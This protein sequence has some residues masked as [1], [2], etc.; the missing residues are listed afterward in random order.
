MDDKSSQVQ[1]KSSQQVTGNDEDVELEGF[2]VSQQSDPT[3]FKKAKLSGD[4]EAIKA[5]EFGT[6]D[7][8]Y[9]SENES[10]PVDAT[11]AVMTQVQ[12]ALGLK[13]PFRGE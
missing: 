8:T 12:I 5:A 7:P 2:L 1:N 11:G 4:L 13:N 10:K 6:E 3:S 9:P